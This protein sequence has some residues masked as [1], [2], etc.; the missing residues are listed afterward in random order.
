MST[1]DAKAAGKQRHRSPNYP[2]FDLK[3]AVERAQQLYDRD[4]THKVPVTVLH[5]RWGYKPMSGALK[6]AIGALKGYGLI[7]VEGEGDKRFVAVSDIGK[8]ILLNA[9]D[10]DELLKKAALGPA[11]FSSLW[12]KYASSGIPSDDVLRHH[13]IFDRNF[14]DE[15]VGDA[16]ARFKATIDFAKLSQGDKM[17]G[18]GGGDDSE[19]DSDN[20]D[21]APPV[22]TARKEKRRM[23]NPAAKEFVYPLDEGPAVLTFPGELS[24]ESVGDLK[25]WL[26][27][28]L[29]KLKRSLPKSSAPPADDDDQDDDDE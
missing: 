4:K 25:E 26:D 18:D 15:S 24:A 29:K 14:N 7:A 28:V 12:T 3:K 13:L 11:L 21:D 9:P 23:S 5:D 19:D 22:N 17:D 1:D 20:E 10:R 2:L 16:I 27:L 8:R 6:Q